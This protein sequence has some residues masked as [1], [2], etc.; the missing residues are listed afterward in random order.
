MN[1]SFPI[2]LLS[3]LPMTFRASVW[4]LLVYHFNARNSW[5]HAF[6]LPNFLDMLL[7]FFVLPPFLLFLEAFSRD[8]KHVP[9]GILRGSATPRGFAECLTETRK[10]AILTC[11]FI[12]YLL[13]AL[14]RYLHYMQCNIVQ[15]TH[16]WDSIQIANAK[17]SE[18]QIVFVPVVLRVAY[19]EVFFNTFHC[20]A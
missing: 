9:F 19:L 2:F 17:H 16:I 7:C 5:L 18:W 8:E 12:C 4:I 13:K 20:D 11:Y 3:F 6:S 10:L 1:P 14:F 15:S